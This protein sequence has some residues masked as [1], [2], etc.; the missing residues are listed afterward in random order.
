MPHIIDLGG[1]PAN[2][3]C[4]SLGHT[5]DFDYINMFEV[6]AYKLAIIARYGAPPEGCRLSPFAHAHDFGTYRTLVLRIDNAAAPEVQAYAQLVEDGLGSWIEA[7]FTPPVTYDGV[8][9]T[10]PR[11]DPAELMIGA[12]L[13]TRPNPDGR[14]AIPAFETIHG[15]LAAAFPEH[16]EIA[17]KRIG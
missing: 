16:A 6:A 17:R 2:E 12:L 11:S 10:V 8:V 4:A 15:N 3:S 1:A 13:T 5:P 9:A 7:C 14:F